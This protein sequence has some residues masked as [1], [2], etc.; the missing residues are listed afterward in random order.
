MEKV[1]VESSKLPLSALEWLHIFLAIGS[2]VG[3]FP[4]PNV[5]EAEGAI[6][7]WRRRRGRRHCRQCLR[8]VPGRRCCRTTAARRQTAAPPSPRGGWG[9]PRR[10][11]VAATVATAATAAMMATAATVGGWALGGVGL[12][13]RGGAAARPA[14]G[15]GRQRWRPFGQGVEGGSGLS[16]A[17][18]PPAQL[19]DG[20]TAADDGAALPAGRV[21]A[22]ITAACDGGASAGVALTAAPV[23]TAATVGDGA[24]GGAGVGGRDR[25]AA[26]PARGGGGSTVG[27]LGGRWAGAGPRHRPFRLATRRQRHG[28]TLSTGGVCVATTAARGGCAV[29]VGEARAATAAA[30]ATVGGAAGG[31]VGV[32]GRGG[33]AARPAHGAAGRVG[34]WLGGGGGG[35]GGRAG[36]GPR[37]RPSCPAARR[38]HGGERR[39]HPP[40]SGDGHGHD[41]GER[42]RQGCRG[43]ERRG[44]RPPRATAVGIAS[45]MP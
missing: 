19:N 18:T 36:A 1:E 20:R 40:H 32:S 41:G 39:R 35:G 23:A 2:C 13:G 11:T 26:R 33:G 14:R 7:H 12:G 37:R 45:G 38:R 16:P 6:G 34:G 27:R 10:R 4:V 17:A 24:R 9:R 25:A 21:E 15:V 8:H 3:L 22:V 28:A 31:G 5:S 30:A 29:A 43:R 44:A 42:R